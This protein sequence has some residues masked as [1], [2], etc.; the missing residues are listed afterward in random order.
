MSYQRP[1]RAILACRPSRLHLP[2]AVK[3][4]RSRRNEFLGFRAIK[5]IYKNVKPVYPK[6]G[7]DILMRLVVTGQSKRFVIPDLL[8][9]MHAGLLINTQ[10]F[11]MQRAAY[12]CDS[13]ARDV[14]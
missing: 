8:N 6:V 13:R 9:Q 14:I 12:F 2:V 11:G 10:A 4:S 5:Y 7:Q 1:R 3:S